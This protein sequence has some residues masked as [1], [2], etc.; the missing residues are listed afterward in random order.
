MDFHSALSIKVDLHT[1]P[2]GQIYP[3]PPLQSPDH[4]RLLLLQL[5]SNDT[6]INC[7]LVATGLH[8]AQAYEAL[9]YT[10]GGL[11][12]HQV[13]HVTAPRSEGPKEF[14]VTSKCFSA[15]A[16][17]RLKE[18]PRILWIDALCLYVN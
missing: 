8:S 9:S 13:I 2:P 18:Q 3:G 4:I 10:W 5:G 6:A 12:S 16:R 14:L 17:L 7:K 1:S 11:A 15:L